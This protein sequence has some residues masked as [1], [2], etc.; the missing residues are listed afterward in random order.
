MH[1][2]APSI[3][4]YIDLLPGVHD[5]AAAIMIP[6]LIV[7]NI[8]TNTDGRKAVGRQQLQETEP[9]IDAKPF[10]CRIREGLSGARETV[11]VAGWGV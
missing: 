2:G 4:I 1:V 8:S 3:E 7:P 11:P 5:G 6:E 10:G 9:E